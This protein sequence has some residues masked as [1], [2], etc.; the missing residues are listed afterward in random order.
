[1]QQISAHDCELS[2]GLLL[3]QD[4]VFNG[5]QIISSIEIQ[6]TSLD[7]GE[8]NWLIANRQKDEIFIKGHL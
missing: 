6:R 8:E 2:M 3:C 5:I 4:A 7:Y 1:M